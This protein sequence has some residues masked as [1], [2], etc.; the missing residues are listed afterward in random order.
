MRPEIRA[1]AVGG[2]AATLVVAAAFAPRLLAGSG[3]QPYRPASDTAV[4]SAEPP[5]T[6]PV[7]VAAEVAAPA[8]ETGP[9]AAPV[10]EAPVT[11][12]RVTKVE[13]KVI[14]IDQRVTILEQRSTTTT[15][16]A[17]GSTTTTT[18]QGRATLPTPTQPVGSETTTTLAPT[19]TTTAK[20]FSCE[21]TT[22]YSNFFHGQALW[23]ATSQKTNP[24]VV[25]VSFHVPGAQPSTDTYSARTEGTTGLA[26]VAIPAHWLD[27]GAATVSGPGV[28]TC[29]AS[30]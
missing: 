24:A 6:V 1:A 8:A 22:I 25:S 28:G 18:A 26:S 29:S 27:R 20:V 5:A 21:A 23:I 11:A 10:G 30:W 16:T 13:E 7:T 17:T 9:Q 15:T 3:A 4:L 14:A 19:T 2:L 12:E